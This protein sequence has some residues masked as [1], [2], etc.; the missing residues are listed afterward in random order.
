MTYKWLRNASPN[1]TIAAFSCG[2]EHSIYAIL[3]LAILAKKASNNHGS[4]TSSVSDVVG[5]AIPSRINTS[6]WKQTKV[7]N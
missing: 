1:F 6:S 5:Q 2:A 4:G 3:T 7:K